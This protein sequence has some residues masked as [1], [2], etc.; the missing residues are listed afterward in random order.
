MK[1]DE[2]ALM[3]RHAGKKLE[4]KSP[5][6]L[7]VLGIGGVVSGTV[8][9]AR[10]TPK[11]RDILEDAGLKDVSV[12]DVPDVVALTWREYLPGIATEALGIFAIVASHRIMT[13]RTVALTGTVATGQ[14]LLR[15]YQEEMAA[16]V[17]EEAVEKIRGNVAERQLT[18]IREEDPDAENQLLYM[19]KVGRICTD[20]FYDGL[21]GRYF[22]SDLQTVRSRV[23]DFNEAI[24]KDVVGY[25]SVNDWYYE[26][27]LD[28]TDMPGDILGWNAQNKLEIRYDTK[29]A[30]N[31]RP[32]IVLDYSPSFP[33]GTYRM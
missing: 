17:S 14:A 19:D 7:V 21:S 26:L 32:C 30:L 24:L 11:A 31:G 23:N 33:V 29:V 4:E 28:M 3:V 2:V 8:M 13:E 15:A 9:I 1:K 18:P 20:L 22:I 10:A 12:K 6:I 27:G 25:G 5:T 16:T